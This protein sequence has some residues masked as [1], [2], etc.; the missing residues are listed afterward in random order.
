MKIIK[1]ENIDKVTYVNY[2]SLHSSVNQLYKNNEGI[3]TVEVKV[4]HLFLL[5]VHLQVALHRSTLFN[6]SSSINFAT[7]EVISS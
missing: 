1:V 5:E 7:Q 4:L 3:I 2:N 6:S